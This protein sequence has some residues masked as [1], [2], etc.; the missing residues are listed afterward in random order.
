MTG[1]R[2]MLVILWIGFLM[3]SP[4]MAGDNDLIPKAEK[5]PFAPG[6]H[7]KYKVQYNLYFNVSVGKITFDIKDSM[8][9]DY[10]QAFHRIVSKGRTLGFYDPFYK[11]RD[12]YET[13]LNME[14]VR[15]TYFMRDVQEGGYTFF[16]QIDFYH[17][18][19]FAMSE[20]GQRHRITTQTQ[21]LLSVLY[22][23]RTLDYEDAQVGDSATFTTFISDSTYTVGVKYMGKTTVK[24]KLGKFR[25]L[26]LKPL[27]VVGRLFDS[28][29]DMTLWVSDDPNKIPVKVRSGISVG[30]IQAQLTD[31]ANLKH[32]LGGK[33]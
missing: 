20:D 16:D 21:D 28:K 9:N 13:C 11:V 4:T 33:K 23:A 15:P 17:N 1:I 7:L 24:T 27:L 22:F 30:R 32:P 2:V 18:Q 10:H 6:E 25:C 3:A 31:Y 8:V 5:M 26:K 29:Y 12:H 14:K 19:R